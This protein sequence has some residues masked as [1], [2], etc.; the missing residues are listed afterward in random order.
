[1]FKKIR[2][3]VTGIALVGIVSV[4]LNSSFS[5]QANH[6][7]VPAPQRP[8]LAYNVGNGGAPSNFYG[9]YPAP[10]EI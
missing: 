8:D 9:D 7:D 10:K 4:G 2:V 1:M 5:Q 3:V 6:G